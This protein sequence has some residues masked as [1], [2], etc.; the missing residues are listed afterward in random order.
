MRTYKRKTDKGNIP[1]SVIEL[2]CKEVILEGKSIRSSALKYN[3]PYKTLH[4]YVTKLKAAEEDSSQ[5]SNIQLT[6]VGY[7]K[8]RQILSGTKE[9]ALVEYIKK[10]A[11][12]YYGLTPK[13]V[14]KLAYQFAIKNGNKVPYSWNEKKMAGEDW[15]TYFLK[16]NNSLSIRSPQATSLFRATSFTNIML[17]CSSQ[18]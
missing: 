3:I 12:I 8:T 16:R 2:A 10:A 1:K 11:D 14:R 15:F 18:I 17:I 13:E 7:N 4:R 6:H 9:I 5:I